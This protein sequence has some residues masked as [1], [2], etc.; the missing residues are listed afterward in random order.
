M[1]FAHAALAVLSFTGIMHAAS[2]GVI[3]SASLVF[4]NN[5]NAA[6]QFK[7]DD[8]YTSNVLVDFTFSYTGTLANNAFTALWFSS[9]EGPSIGLKA[10]CGDGSRSCAGKDIFARTAGQG[11]AFVPGSVLE[12][13]KSYT[14]VG[15]LQKTNGSE[16]YN[17][18]DAWVN[19]ASMKL[20]DLAKNKTYASFTSATKISSFDTMGI[21][22]VNLNGQA[23]TTID[24]IHVTAIPEPGSIALMGLALACMGAAARRKRK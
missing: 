15:Y 8:T 11:G 9:W 13:G 19:P 14:I 4:N 22:T 7:L 2:A 12:A 18:F 10:N 16:F 23:S 17:R 3:N 5:A 24:K 1:K 6:A 20:S 21:R